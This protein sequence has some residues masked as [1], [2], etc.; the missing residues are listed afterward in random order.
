MLFYSIQKNKYKSMDKYTLWGMRALINIQFI[1][2][3]EKYIY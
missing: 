2:Y 1:D 3:P